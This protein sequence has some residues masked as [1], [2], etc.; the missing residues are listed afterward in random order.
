MDAL[1]RNSWTDFIG[2]YAYI[3]TSKQLVD[4]LH[5]QDTEFAAAEAQPN[6]FLVTTDRFAPASS[7][8]TIL[9]CN[10]TPRVDNSSND[11]LTQ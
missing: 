9:V 3:W 5:K 8:Q 2:I 7:G 11:A 4:D 6:F 10:K 1:T